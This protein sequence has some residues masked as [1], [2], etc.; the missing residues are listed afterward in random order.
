MNKPNASESGLPQVPNDPSNGIPDITPEQWARLRARSRQ[1]EEDFV[2][3]QSLFPDL[4]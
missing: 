4:R 1:Y 3:T 2:P